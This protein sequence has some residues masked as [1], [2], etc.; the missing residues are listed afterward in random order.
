M[1]PKLIDGMS[2]RRNRG[3]LLLAPFVRIVCQKALRTLGHKGVVTLRKAT[4]SFDGSPDR[5]LCQYA[6]IFSFKDVPFIVDF[7]NK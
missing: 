5:L 3:K 7:S 1:L 4:S 6:L 2:V